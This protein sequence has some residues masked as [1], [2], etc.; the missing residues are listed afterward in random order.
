M[1]RK[2][3]KIQKIANGILRHFTAMDKGFARVE[4]DVRQLKRFRNIC[5]TANEKLCDSLSVYSNIKSSFQKR[6]PLVSIV[7]DKNRRIQISE[8]LMQLRQV[9]GECLDMIID[10]IDQY[11]YSGQKSYSLEAL[12]KF[13]SVIE[14]EFREL[15]QEVNSLK[16]H[17]IL[18]DRKEQLMET[19]RLTEE[20]HQKK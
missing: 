7:I 19:I 10:Y 12:Q 17:F 18:E 6:D 4:S 15:E 3:E 8:S 5:Y 13:K 1:I 9:A 16:M 2:L 11:P 14:E 20:E